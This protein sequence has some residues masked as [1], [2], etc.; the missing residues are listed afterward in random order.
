MQSVPSPLDLEQLSRS[1]SHRAFKPSDYRVTYVA[2]AEAHDLFASL[3][4]QLCPPPTNGGGSFGR[5][6]DSIVQQD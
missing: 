3:P 2:L 4:S 6:K 5:G 1:S